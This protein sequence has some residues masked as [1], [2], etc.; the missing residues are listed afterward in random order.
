M[1]P[2]SSRWVGAGGKNRRT[3]FFQEDRR[4]ARTAG[5]REQEVW[6][7]QEDRRRDAV[8]PC[9]FTPCVITCSPTQSRSPVPRPPRRVPVPVLQPNPVLLFPVP[10]RR[11]PVPVPLPNPVLLFHVP[12]AASRFLFSCQ[13]PF[14]CSPS[15]APRPGSCSPAQSRSPVPRPPRRGQ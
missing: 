8:G 5:G 2:P 6:I 13:I 14:S 3:R 4:R 1:R 12:R 15:P 9:Q 11:V 7:L 10:P